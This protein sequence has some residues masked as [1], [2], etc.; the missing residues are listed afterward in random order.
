MEILELTEYIVKSIVKN[1]EKIKIEKE[2]NKIIIKV[3]E[4]DISL[5]I[6]PNGIV[7]NSIRTII[8][9]SSYSLNKESI[10]IDIETY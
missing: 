8:Q 2:N 3:S 7:A 4:E 1:K 5:L 6:G 9:A 10:R